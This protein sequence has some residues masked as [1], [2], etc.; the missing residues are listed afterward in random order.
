MARFFTV[1]V[2]FVVAFATNEVVAAEDVSWG[3]VKALA[4]DQT[5]P[6]GKLTMSA[7][8]SCG[9]EHVLFAADVGGGFNVLKVA[10]FS[11]SRNGNDVNI[12]IG[13]HEF[14]FSLDGAAFVLRFRSGGEVIILY[15][16]DVEYKIGNVLIHF[17]YKWKG[18]E[19]QERLISLG[20][21]ENGVEFM[22]V[23]FI[24]G[25]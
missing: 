12:I 20:L 8:T 17:K 14:L 3:Q 9:R 10:K 1:L 22:E 21:H 13:L 5:E 4:T 18:T 15:S 16:T 19:I 24:P 7:M 2:I 11:A 6:A 23:I 25:I